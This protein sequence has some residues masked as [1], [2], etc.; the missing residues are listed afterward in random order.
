[1]INEQF[2]KNVQLLAP[3]KAFRALPEAIPELSHIGALSTN[4]CGQK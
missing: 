1:M 4:G 2:A 3:I